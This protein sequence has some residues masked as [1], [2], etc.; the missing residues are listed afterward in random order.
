MKIVRKTCRGFTLIEM[1]MVISITGIIAGMVAIFIRAPV[2]GYFD[3]ESR[4]GLTDMADTALRRMGRDVRLALP[5]SVRTNG[6]ALEFLQTNTGGRY[7]SKVSGVDGSGTPLPLPGGPQRTTFDV[8]GGMPVLPGNGNWLVVYNTGDTGANA[9]AGGNLAQI[10]SATPAGDSITLINNM[11]FPQA[12]PGNRFQVVDTPVTYRCANGT[13]T[14]HWGYGIVSAQPDPPSGGSSAIIA[15]GITGCG[16]TYQ[17]NVV[18]QSW[19]LVTM[20]LQMSRN[21]ERVTLI[22][23]V[24]VSNVP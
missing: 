14:R 9:Y 11:R 7:R 8:I 2:Q 5:N 13:L 18:N 19:G 1:I 15:E 24:H 17:Q 3:M 16:F 20:T 22:H 21:N 6:T 12:S 4:A 23:E 10:S